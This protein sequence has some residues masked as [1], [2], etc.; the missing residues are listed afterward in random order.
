MICQFFKTFE[1]NISF[2]ILWKIFVKRFCEKVFWKGFVKRFCEKVL[3]KGFVISFYYKIIC[4]DNLELHSYRQLLSL[5][6]IFYIC[7]CWKTWHFDNRFWSKTGLLTVLWIRI[8]R[9]KQI[10][11]NAHIYLNIHLAILRK[12]SFSTFAMDKIFSIMSL[13]QLL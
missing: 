9:Q 10:L 6:F 13:S 12:L 2:G 11:F 5:F 3:W 1:Q 8:R 4:F 7:S